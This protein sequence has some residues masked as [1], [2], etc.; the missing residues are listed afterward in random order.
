FGYDKACYDDRV[1]WV[2]DHE[3]E[4]IQS[5][6]APE[7]TDFWC[8]DKV[9]S[10]FCFLAACFEWKAY[11]QS[12]RSRHFISHIPV[13][14]DGSCSG[15][16]HYS[17]MLLDEIG[18]LATNVKMLPNATRKED[19]YQRVADE[20]IKL[21]KHDITDPFLKPEYIEW[22]TLCIAH[23]LLDRSVVKRAVMTLPYGSTFNSCSHYIREN[24]T[25][26]LF[27]AGLPQDKLLTCT[28]FIAG[29]VWKAIPLVVQAARTGMDYLKAL[30]T[31]VA[32][33]G[34]PVTWT[35]P[36]GFVVQ[37]SYY[38]ADSERIRLATGETITIKGG[39]PVWTPDKT[40]LVTFK[41]PDTKR[42]DKKRQ[43]SGIAPN[44]IHSLDASHLM[45]TVK[46]AAQQGIQDFALIHDSLATHAGKT[47]QFAQIIRQC[48]HDLY[49]LHTPLEDIT[50]HLSA[51]ITTDKKKL[52]DFP[53]KGTLDLKE[54]L[55][56]LYL[57]S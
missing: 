46:A 12:G 4:I 44:F 38:E 43:I 28:A 50:E 5:A 39:I 27:A 41:K 40:K 7:D 23:N 53:D 10:P 26:A 1:Q 25:A 55:N 36:T 20:T 18:A 6:T 8:S 16:Q 52:P 14:L 54:I 22:A 29:R 34:L 49:A 57:F 13:A 9:D 47:E 19:I 30:A 42:I 33:E 11:V 21:L 17:A 35:T 51:Q 37:Q 32:K 31:L 15:I 24:I 48:F 2:L 56:A 45:F 3:K